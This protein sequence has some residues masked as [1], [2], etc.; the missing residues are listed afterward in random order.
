M[1]INISEGQFNR[2]QITEGVYD[3]TAVNMSRKAS[4]AG[5]LCAYIQFEIQ[6]GEFQ[7]E[8]VLGMLV[9]IDSVMWKSNQL[10]KAIT[11]EDIP[12]LDFEDENEF[13]DWIWEQV[14]GVPLRVKATERMYNDEVRLELEYLTA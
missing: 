1:K 9:V 12:Q 2:P 5:N 13:L 7:G 10:I 6:D 8:K 3:V 14:N 11:G 4:S